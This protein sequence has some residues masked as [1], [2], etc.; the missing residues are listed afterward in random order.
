VI[1]TVFAVA[2]AFREREKERE[3]KRGRERACINKKIPK[4]A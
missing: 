3:R 2:E 1:L 4:N